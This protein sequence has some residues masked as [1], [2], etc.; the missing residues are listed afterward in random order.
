M[1]GRFLFSRNY[2]Y[3]IGRP[4][5]VLLIIAR[6]LWKCM[7]IEQEFHLL[8]LLV[9]VSIEKKGSADKV[10]RNN[11]AKN[12][13]KLSQTPSFS[14]IQELNENFDERKGP[15]LARKL[16]RA[17]SVS[18]ITEVKEDFDERKGSGWIST[19][20]IIFSS[21]QQP[22]W[23]SSHSKAPNLARKLSKAPS[24]AQITEVAEDFDEKFGNRGTDVR[25]FS[26]QFTASERSLQELQEDLNE[27]V[28][29][30]VPSPK[31]RGKKLSITPSVA[32]IVEEFD[33][34]CLNLFENLST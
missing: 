25:K 10:F 1:E 27:L 4:N 14:Q 7:T 26:K 18:Q 28:G 22:I 20:E 16:S 12:S 13:R 5:S 23:I 2:F 33:E 30:N 9:G 32:A 3:S 29:E 19:V 6:W 21:F 11:F 17:P 31:K 8:L 24:V 34:V 15:N